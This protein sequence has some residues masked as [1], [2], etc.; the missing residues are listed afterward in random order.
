MIENSL[1]SN[2]VY[3]PHPLHVF[4]PIIQLDTIELIY[5]WYITL[6]YST[7]ER[8]K[9]TQRLHRHRRNGG[10]ELRICKHNATCVSTCVMTLKHLSRTPNT[11]DGVCIC[12]DAILQWSYINWRGACNVVLLVACRPLLCMALWVLFFS[13]HLPTFTIPL[14]MCWLDLLFFI[15]SNWGILPRSCSH[16]CITKSEDN[17]HLTSHKYVHIVHKAWF[18][19]EVLQVQAH[20]NQLT[21]HTVAEFKIAGGFKKSLGGIQK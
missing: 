21:I 14:W 3:L 17:S 15:M 10:I 8:A 7:V 5:N 12:Q 9:L 13:I 6:I 19:C 4:R 18:W 11:M 2:G 20:C 16:F 1:R